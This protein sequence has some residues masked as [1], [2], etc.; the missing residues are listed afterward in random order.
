M[1]DFRDPAIF[2][3]CVT[4]IDDPTACTKHPQA[5]VVPTNKLRKRRPDRNPIVTVSE[6]G[7]VIFGVKRKDERS[8]CDVLPGLNNGEDMGEDENGGEE[9]TAETSGVCDWDCT[10]PT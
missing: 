6:G 5:L 8:L 7:A 1:W 4:C 9:P 10:M 2:E 3:P